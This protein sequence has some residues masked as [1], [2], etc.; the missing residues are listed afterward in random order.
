MVNVD[1]SVG[2]CVDK[3]CGQNPHVARQHHQ[4][5]LMIAQELELNVLCGLFVLG[6]HRNVVERHV[7]KIGAPLGIV[8]IADNQRDITGE[9]TNLMPVQKIS[10]AMM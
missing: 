4:I 9:F 7:V 10:Q 6:S 3:I 8:M 2:I 5:N 1:D